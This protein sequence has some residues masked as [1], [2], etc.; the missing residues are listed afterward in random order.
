MKF[1]K[2]PSPNDIAKTII[3]PVTDFIERVKKTIMGWFNKITDTVRG[4]FDVLRT[5]FTSTLSNF[6]NQ[7]VAIMRDRMAKPVVSI[8]SMVS[9][10]FMDKFVAPAQKFFDNL[11]DDMKKGFYKLTDSLE[12]IWGDIVAMKQHVA[13]IIK[14]IEC[15]IKKIENFP[16]CFKWYIVECIG[17]MIYTPWGFFF[18]LTSTQNIEKEIWDLVHYIDTEFIYY[19]SGFY[20]FQ[21]SNEIQNRCYRCDAKDDDPR[22]KPLIQSISK[23]SG[24]DK[25]A[26][27]YGMILTRFFAATVLLFIPYYFMFVRVQDIDL[28]VV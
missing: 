12:N 23:D 24:P 16:K 28:N 25:D 1:P 22:A 18:W 10:G 19:Y 4:W 7:F 20:M 26:A 6:G 3:S 11:F 27:L 5:F 17:Q 14:Y 8:W 9:K 21:Y 13:D 2:I 15:S